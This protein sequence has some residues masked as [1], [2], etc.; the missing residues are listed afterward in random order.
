MTR[1][2][3]WLR[4]NAAALATVAVLLPATAFV[5]LGLPA[6]EVA[7]SVDTPRLVSPGETVNTQGFDYTLTDSTETVGEGVDEN[8][9]PLGTSLVV[10]RFE[11]EPDGSTP[12]ELCDVVLTDRSDAST[13]E[14]TWRPQISA[15]TY[16]Y[17]AELGTRN[18]CNP[19]RDEPQVLEMV[20]LTPT[21]V[22]GT[23]T[24]DF[25]L[26][27]ESTVLLRFALA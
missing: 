10:A 23:A 6:L 19:A 18:F 2:N 3:A 16:G 12:A 13:G 22:Y 15:S 20:F 26:T 7:D 27:G 25:T 14:R 8:R 11:V 21:D 24:V 1:R 4:R 5:L 9:I 17:T